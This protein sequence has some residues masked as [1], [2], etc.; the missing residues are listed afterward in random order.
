MIESE[1][2]RLCLV[3]TKIMML[4]QGHIIFTGSDEELFKSDDPYIRE[5]V[6]EF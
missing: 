2:E 3:N 4:R 1:G 6:R 5:F